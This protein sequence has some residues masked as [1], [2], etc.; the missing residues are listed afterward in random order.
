M[1]EWIIHSQTLNDPK[2][3]SQF[4]YELL[5]VLLHKCN[6]LLKLKKEVLTPKGPTMNYLP[7]QT[8]RLP[9]I[10]QVLFPPYGTLRFNQ[11]FPIMS[12]GIDWPS[13]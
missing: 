7:L 4:V 9:V 10:L 8:S 2:Q 5:N 13:V 1:L 12:V 3:T 6:T 11:F